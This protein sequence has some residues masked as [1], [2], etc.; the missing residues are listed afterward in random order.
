[1]HKHPNIKGFTITEVLVALTSVIL[2]VAVLLPTLSNAQITSRRTICQFNL[3][4]FVLATE[5]YTQDN[6]NYYICGNPENTPETRLWMGSEWK[7]FLKQYIS[8]MDVFNCP[9]TS[10]DV[11]DNKIGSYVYSMSFYHSKEQINKISD[12]S[13]TFA[14][15]SIIPPVK[16][17]TE[18]VAAPSE[19]IIFG[20][21]NSNHALISDDNG[22]WNWNGK[23]NFIFADSHT[24]FLDAE[25]INRANDDLPDANVTIDGIEGSDYN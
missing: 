9:S 17:K 7:N 23:R 12:Y 15:S 21:W 18:S 3:R 1:M 8:D 4:N 11:L 22:W 16:Q 24:A 19:K 25:K 14:P 2:L 6:D 13:E 10:D 5:V 20:E